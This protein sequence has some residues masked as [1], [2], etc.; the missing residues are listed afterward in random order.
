[1]HELSNKTKENEYIIAGK[2]REKEK[3]IE[4]LKEQQLDSAEAIEVFSVRLTKVL[5]DIEILKKSK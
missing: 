2:L 1:V 5:E 3:E 4:G